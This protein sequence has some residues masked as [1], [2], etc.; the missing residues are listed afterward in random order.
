VVLAVWEVWEAS[1]DLV[2]GERALGWET[3]VVHSWKPSSQIDVSLTSFC[4]VGD[5]RSLFGSNK[6]FVS[7]IR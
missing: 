7:R 1:A 4:G 5:D 6:S 2:V 3:I